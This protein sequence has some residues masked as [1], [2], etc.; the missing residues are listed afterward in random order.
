MKCFDED[1]MIWL[2]VIVFLVIVEFVVIE[3]L[4]FN[5]GDRIVTKTF[6]FVL[7]FFD[8]IS[9]FYFLTKLETLHPFAKSCTQH[10]FPFKFLFNEDWR[11]P[12]HHTFTVSMQLFHCR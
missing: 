2:Q 6:C 3:M 7:C 8:F 10:S 1:F 12:N 11:L 4:R 5:V 9:K